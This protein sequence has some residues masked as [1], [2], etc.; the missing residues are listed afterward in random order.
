M[1]LLYDR[2]GSAPYPNEAQHQESTQAP[3]RPF[4][5]GFPDLAR[6]SLRE[7][8]MWGITP[9][10]ELWCRLRF[11]RVHYEGRFTPPGLQD[12]LIYP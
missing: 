7:C 3:P 2:Y 11:H 5:S 12:T 9:Y 6:P 4:S 1:A 10:D 8:E